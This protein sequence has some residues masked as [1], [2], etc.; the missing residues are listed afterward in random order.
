ME[1]WLVRI[2]VFLSLIFSANFCFAEPA[3]EGDINNCALQWTERGRAF[4]LEISRSFDDDVEFVV[5]ARDEDPRELYILVAVSKNMFKKQMIATSEPEATITRTKF[6][7]DSATYNRLMRF[8]DFALDY[9]VRDAQRMIDGSTWCLE[10]KWVNR[11][12][13]RACFASPDF[14]SEKRK[15]VGLLELG[16]ELW[17]IASAELD[18]GRLY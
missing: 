2:L 3:T 14:E 5:C 17:T 13:R 6:D 16:K 4:L 8:Y 12:E 9:D 11:V 10:R 1:E 7:I 18:I 15:L